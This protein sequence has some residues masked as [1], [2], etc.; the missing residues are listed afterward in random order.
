MACRGTSPAARARPL[1]DA[2]CSA[3]PRP[4][5]HEACLRGRCRP[6]SQLQW[7]VSAWSQVRAP[8]PAPPPLHSTPLEQHPTGT[9]EA[10]M[11]G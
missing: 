3:E 11:S 10:S 8:G 2:L 1:P 7:L 5:T 4:R 6:P 9:H